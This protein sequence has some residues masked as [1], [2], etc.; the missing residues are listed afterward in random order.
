MGFEEALGIVLST[1]ILLYES[2]RDT[3]VT[4][5]LG[6]CSVLQKFL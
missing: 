2:Q 5:L 4:F 1:A 6:S 3:P